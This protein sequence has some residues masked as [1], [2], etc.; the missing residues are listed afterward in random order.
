MLLVYAPVCHWVWGSGG[1]LFEQG[2]RDFAGGLV[3][4]ATAGSSALV[5][6]AM[7]GKRK[8]FPHE[9]RP[10]HSP[11]LVMIGAAMLWVGWYGFNAGSRSRRRTEPP[12]TPC[13]SPTSRP[14]PQR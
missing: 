4:H 11:V 10:P 6:A 13:W 8:H 12:A 3:V 9:M 2:V 1:W 5:I 7:V 14:P